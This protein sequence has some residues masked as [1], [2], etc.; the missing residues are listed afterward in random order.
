[1]TRLYLI[2]PPRIE[3][4]PIFA[5]ELRAALGGGDVAAFQLRLKD[6]PDEA[7]VVGIPAREAS[8]KTASADLALGE[9]GPGAPASC[10]FNAYGEA[11]D[12]KDPLLIK[13]EQLAN[14]T[15]AL[16]EK[17]ARLENLPPPDDVNRP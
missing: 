17:L 10:A 7:T 4:P 5:A 16:E 13:L 1:M 2:S 8:S 6:V 11:Q 15:R 3:H 9:A 12:L 14:Q